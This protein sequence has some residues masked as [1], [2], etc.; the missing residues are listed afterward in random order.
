MCVLHRYAEGS[1]GWVKVRE[2]CGVVEWGEEGGKKRGR[3]C[4]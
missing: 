4:A 3:E 2:E 1:V